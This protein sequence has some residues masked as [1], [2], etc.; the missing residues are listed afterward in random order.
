M[1]TCKNK[2]KKVM[3]FKILEAIN[4]QKNPN[5]EVVEHQV[6]HLLSV[7]KNMHA[8]VRTLMGTENLS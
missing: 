5:K 6:L 2:R 3:F 7:V 4:T 8:T 1:Y